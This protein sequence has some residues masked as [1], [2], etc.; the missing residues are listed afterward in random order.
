MHRNIDNIFDLLVYTV[1]TMRSY[2]YDD[3]SVTEY[4]DDVLSGN[5]LDIIEISREQLDRCNGVTLSNDASDDS[6]ISYFNDDINDY[7]CLKHNY[8]ESESISLWDDDGR[9]DIDDFELY[10]GFSK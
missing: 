10:E 6:T 4:L 5:K 9:Y 7:E 2:G 3:R 8:Y 1:K